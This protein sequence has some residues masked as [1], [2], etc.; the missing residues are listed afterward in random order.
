MKV[1]ALISGGKDS[2]FNMMECVKRGHEIV[3]LAN[4][5]PPNSVS[6]RN[7]RIDDDDENNKKELE[8]ELDSYMY[9]SVGNEMLEMYAQAMDL[10]LYRADIRGQVLN[11]KLDYEPD[12]E[13][14]EVEDLYRLL[15]HVKEDMAS[16]HGIQVEAVSS[17]AIFST[18]QKN[19]VENVC[20]RLGLESLAYLWMRNQ[21][22]LL[23]DM[24]ESNIEAILI[25]VAC[26]GLSPHK[27]LGKTI[28]ELK[29]YLHELEGKYGINMCG[30]GGEYES[31]TLDCPLFKK[32]RIVVDD[33]Q[34][35]IHSNDAFAPVGYL[36]FKKFHLEDK[37]NSN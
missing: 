34:L 19:R 27:H 35:C 11:T 5:R 6:A 29:P 15:A 24:I 18:Y 31:L 33:T 14:D 10:P 1:I 25:K 3:A 8:Q 37:I 7:E 30:E 36:I 21:Y 12:D 2:T 32:K 9:Q 22:E 20:K 28:G 16:K 23:T 13:N 17:G 26:I 4:L